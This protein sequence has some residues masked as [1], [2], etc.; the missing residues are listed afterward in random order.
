MEHFLRGGKGEEANK[1][2]LRI[3]QVLPQSSKANKLPLNLLMSS[4]HELAA[5]IE[6]Y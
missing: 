4:A 6:E 3:L 2:K 1:K 5:D